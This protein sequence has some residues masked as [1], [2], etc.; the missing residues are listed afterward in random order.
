MDG[1]GKGKV[2]PL[3][4]MKACGGIRFYFTLDG[5]EW[6]ASRPGRFTLWEKAAPLPGTNNYYKVFCII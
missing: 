3:R 5:S 2:V 6:P 4:A 1:K